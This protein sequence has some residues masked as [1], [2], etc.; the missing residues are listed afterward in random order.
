[1]ETSF[2]FFMRPK[3]GLGIMLRCTP[4]RKTTTFWGNVQKITAGIRKGY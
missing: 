1:V 3:V 2:T 4:L